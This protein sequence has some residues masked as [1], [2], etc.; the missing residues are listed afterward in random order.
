VWQ[1]AAVDRQ[2]ALQATARDEVPDALRDRIEELSLLG[3]ERTL[4]RP[5]HRLR[6]VDLDLAGDVAL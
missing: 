6:V 2:H 3:Q 1:A 4:V 5:R